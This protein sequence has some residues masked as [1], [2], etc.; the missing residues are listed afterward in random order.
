MTFVLWEL[1]AIALSARSHRCTVNV[2]ACDAPID[3]AARFESYRS[4]DFVAPDIG[5]VYLPVTHLLQ[6]IMTLGSST[7]LQVLSNSLGTEKFGGTIDRN[8]LWLGSCSSNQALFVAKIS[9]QMLQSDCS[10]CVHSN[11]LLTSFKQ[12]EQD[13]MTSGSI[14][15]FHCTDM[16]R[17]IELWCSLSW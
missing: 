15:L 13:L 12:D 11:L 7:H 6:C 9:Q 10:H 5:T 3:C 16:N 14:F 1:F 17:S 8:S 2:S 4:S